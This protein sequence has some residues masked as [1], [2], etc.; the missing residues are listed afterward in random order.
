M[1]EGLSIIVLGLTVLAFVLKHAL[2]HMTCVIAWLF[3]GFYMWNQSWPAGNTYLGTA[4]IFFALI[5]VI[6]NLIVALN[7]YLGQR[8]VPS[9]H[10]EI[11]AIHRRK[12]LNITRRKEPGEIEEPW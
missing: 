6:V 4:F 10:E 1:T 5:M 12:V 8:T 7:H 3:Y 9:T 11:Q 2:L